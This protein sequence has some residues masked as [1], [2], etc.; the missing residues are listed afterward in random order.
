MLVQVRCSLSAPSIAKPVVA[1]QLYGNRSACYLKLGEL[2]EALKDA[3]KCLE[4]DPHLW[5]GYHR[6]GQIL[7]R[8]RQFD[9]AV[10]T[11]MVGLK[12]CQG[13]EDLL[14]EFGRYI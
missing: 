10:E 14:N 4:L 3:E 7:F 1:S 8:M 12:R 9:L 11:Y 6:R 5:M 2:H 13:N